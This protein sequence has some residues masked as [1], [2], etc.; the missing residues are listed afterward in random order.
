MAAVTPPPAGPVT[1]DL[2]GDLKT[3]IPSPDAEPTRPATV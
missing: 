2:S 1:G 3:T